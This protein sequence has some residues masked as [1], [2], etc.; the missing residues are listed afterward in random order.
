MIQRSFRICED[1]LDDL[2]TLAEE[3]YRGRLNVSDL[4]RLFLDRGIDSE[5]GRQ[6]GH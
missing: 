5:Y 2:Q 3:K 6:N 4:L 1:Q